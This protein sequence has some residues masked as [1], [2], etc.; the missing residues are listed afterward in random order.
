M[1]STKKDIDYDTKLADKS[2]RFP[3]FAVDK[4][5]AESYGVQ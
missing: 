2:A 5:D 1:D 4:E 3:E